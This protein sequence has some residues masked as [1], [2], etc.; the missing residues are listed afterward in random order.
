MKKKNYLRI[1]ALV[2]GIVLPTIASLTVVSCS[3][4]SINRNIKTISYDVA[5]STSSKT[6]MENVLSPDLNAN[7]LKEIE[8]L[9]S[10]ITKEKLQSDFNF[11]LTDFYEVYEIENSS[12]EIELEKIEVLSY[13]MKLQ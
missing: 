12:F 5:T 9:K 1:G 13:T 7:A 3:T 10:T 2:S 6:N 4:S 11:A 8:K